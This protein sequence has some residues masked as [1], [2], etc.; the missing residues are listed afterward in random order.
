MGN[1]SIPTDQILAVVTTKVD[2]IFDPGRLRRDVDAVA[3]LGWFADVSARLESEPGGVRILYLVVENPVITEIVVE[4]NT[5]IGLPDILRALNIPTGQVLN[6]RRT[7]EGVRAVEKLYESRGY[8]LARVTDI[9]LEPAGDGRLR[10]RIAEGRVEDIVFTGLA[11]TRPSTARRFVLLK[12]NDV[13]NLQRMNADLQRLFESGLFETVEARPR[14][15]STADTVIVEIEVKEA[16]TGQLGLGIGYSTA[17]GLIGSI[18][19]SDRNWRGTAQTISLR[20]ERGFTRGPTGQGSKYDFTLSFQ[21]PFL[22][23]QGTALGINLFQT[24]STQIEVTGGE[25]TSRYDLDRVGSF[26]QLSRPLNP[27]TSVSVRLRSELATVTPLPLTPGGICPDDCP[28]PTNF[29]D[30]RTVSVTLA[31]ARDTRDNRIT[32][33]KG[34]RQTLS[35]EFALPALGSKFDF[36]KYY[37]EYVQYVP[38]GGR[39]V[40]AGRVAGGF[41]SGFIPLQEEFSLG[42]ATTLRGFQIGRFRGSSLALANVEFRTPLDFIG[43]FLEGFTGVV[44]VDGGQTWGASGNEGFKVDYGVGVAFKSPLGVLRLDYAFGP[45]GNQLWLNLG[46]PF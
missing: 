3:E 25:P 8:V 20:A 41:G 32:P 6:S 39:S 40:I 12:K 34:S 29:S 38:L 11:K 19:F 31:G 10:L 9:G 42:G 23:T 44:F 26:I 18:E 17:A 14:P 35:L 21:D 43:S 4:G 33:T 45:E 13:F 28:P 22:D 46:H 27:H 15:G 2:D 5:V 16:L 24:S 1:R 37:A 36:Q 7:R 30:G